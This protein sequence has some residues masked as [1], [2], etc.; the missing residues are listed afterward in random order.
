MC[1]LASHILC[2]LC[3]LK[4]YTHYAIIYLS[5]QV[6]A[7][8]LHHLPITASLSSPKKLL[9][10]INFLPIIYK[11]EIQLGCI[12]EAALVTKI[13]IK[14][15]KQKQIVRNY[16]SMFTVHKTQYNNTEELL[17]SNKCR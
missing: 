8:Q 11:L 13:N 5:E 4:T 10:C 17:K 16:A 7:Q 12:L 15:Y 3:S 1:C 6:G 9:S 14:K 2:G